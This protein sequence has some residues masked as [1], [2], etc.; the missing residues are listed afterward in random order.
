MPAIR[1]DKIPLLSEE[2]IKGGAPTT[3][4]PS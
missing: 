2:G 1:I 3:P 4:D